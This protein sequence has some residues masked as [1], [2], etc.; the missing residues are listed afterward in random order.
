ML[1]ALGHKWGAWTKTDDNQ[2]QRVCEND[3]SHVEK[4]SHIGDE[5]EVTK[6]GRRFVDDAGPKDMLLANTLIPAPGYPWLAWTRADDMQ[7]QTT[8]GNTPTH[9]EEADYSGVGSRLST[10]PAPTQT[11][12]GTYTSADN[13]ATQIASTPAPDTASVAS[14]VTAPAKTATPATGD[15]TAAWQVLAPVFLGGLALCAADF[16]KCARNRS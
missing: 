12:V 5:G 3:P 10:E 4:A 15:V 1:R 6:S 2:Y 8:N 16:A 11:G 9:V 13:G 7:R 14:T